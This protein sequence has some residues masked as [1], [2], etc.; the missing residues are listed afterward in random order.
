MTETS[1]RTI[2][3]KDGVVVQKDTRPRLMYST[4][5]WGNFLVRLHREDKKHLQ[6]LY[7]FLA[8]HGYDVLDKKDEFALMGRLSISSNWEKD[9]KKTFRLVKI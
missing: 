8:E 1:S 3:E 2:S 7:L 9:L 5:Q 4:D 6:R